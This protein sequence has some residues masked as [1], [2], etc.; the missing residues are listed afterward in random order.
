[1]INKIKGNACYV[2]V[3]MFLLTYL[4]NNLLQAVYVFDLVKQKN[5][6]QL[7]ID[8]LQAEQEDVKDLVK[9]IGEKR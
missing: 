5:A 3:L 7:Q 2:V 8:I 6:L 4:L 1:M 9:R